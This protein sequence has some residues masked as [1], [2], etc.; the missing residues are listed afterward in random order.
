M[1]GL[2]HFLGMCH[3]GFQQPLSAKYAGMPSSAIAT[4]LVDYVLPPEAM[5]F[6]LVAYVKGP[7]LQGERVI[8]NMNVG[9]G[10]ARSRRYCILFFI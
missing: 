1:D 7:Y 2:K 4:G 9:I 6:Q 3:R 8:L 5:P 10:E